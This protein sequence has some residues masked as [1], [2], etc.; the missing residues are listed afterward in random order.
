[1]RSGTVA[2]S[3]ILL[4]GEGTRRERIVTAGVDVIPGLVTITSYTQ[5]TTYCIG[6]FIERATGGCVSDGQPGV[7]WCAREGGGDVI[8]EHPPLGGVW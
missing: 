2:S 6:C 4:S 5:S 3:G 1:M 7:S 8:A